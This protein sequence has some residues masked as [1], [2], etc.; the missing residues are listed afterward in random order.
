M[1]PGAPKPDRQFRDGDWRRN[2]GLLGGIPQAERRARSRLRA[3][4]GGEVGTI[5]AMKTKGRLARD[6]MAV[7][8]GFEPTVGVNLHTLSKRAPSTTRPPHQHHRTRA[9][10]SPRRRKARNIL[11]DPP[12]ASA[13]WRRGGGG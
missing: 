2:G 12:G 3:V 5:W 10:Q 7:R 13:H 8:V 4:R 11:I 6:W 1:A 9:G